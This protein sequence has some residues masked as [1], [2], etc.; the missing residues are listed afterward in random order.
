MQKRIGD[1]L[2]VFD[3][4]PFVITDGTDAESI[5]V[6]YEHMNGYK[7]LNPELE[8]K[9]YG[10]N[11]FIMTVN[12]PVW[13]QDVPESQGYTFSLSGYDIQSNVKVYFDDVEQTIT[14]GTWSNVAEGTEIYISAEENPEWYTVT[15]EDPA[16]ILTWNQSRLGWEITM[17]TED[18]SVSIDY[19]EDVVPDTF[20][21]TFTLSG[22]D[23][24]D[25]VQVTVND[26]ELTLDENGQAL[27]HENDVVKIEPRNDSSEY[28]LVSGAEWNEDA[29]Y[30]TMPAE[31]H[32]VVINYTEPQPEG[33]T[34]T[35]STNDSSK[36]TMTINGDSYTPSDGNWSNIMENDEIRIYPT[37]PAEMQTNYDDQS[38]LTVDS[39]DPFG[40]CWVATMPDNDYTITIDYNGG[41]SGGDTPDSY[42]FTFLTNDSSAFGL[43][44]NG[45]SKDP[46]DGSWND[47]LED[48]EIIITLTDPG[49]TSGTYSTSDDG[50]ASVIPAWDGTNSYYYLTMPDHDIQVHIDYV[51]GESGES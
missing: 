38:N 10:F 11:Q 36:F 1:K 48:E 47:V 46:S 15:N 5:F 29:W 6:Q 45:V 9:I 12:P 13:A 19:H 32:T 41:E 40:T 21:Y 16:N 4:T 49:Q 28:E 34:L 37:I 31:D 25:A 33:H 43:S 24:I 35:F 22:T 2:Y 30:C 23:I 51:G 7:E 27:L 3:L 20:T 17:P 18:V 26:S 50:G 39:D 44:I 8:D 42:T 14:D